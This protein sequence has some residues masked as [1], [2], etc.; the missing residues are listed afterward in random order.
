MKPSKKKRNSRKIL[1]AKRAKKLREIDLNEAMRIHMRRMFAYV[2][3]SGLLICAAV[4]IYS[5]T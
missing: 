4:I 3:L 2:V 5:S 1:Q